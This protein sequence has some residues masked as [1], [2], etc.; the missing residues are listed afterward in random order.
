MVPGAD[1][2]FKTTTFNDLYPYV[3]QLRQSYG[4]EVDTDASF[5]EI[6]TS[7]T[8]F[9]KIVGVV[10]SGA[11]ECRSWDELLAFMLD[12]IASAEDVPSDRNEM[13]VFAMRN[14]WMVEVCNYI[15]QVIQENADIDEG[16]EDGR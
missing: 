5:D 9:R 7:I 10:R 8:R 1:D 13:V 2:L 12:R 16:V 15:T 3:R 14:N 11:E 4:M 6:K